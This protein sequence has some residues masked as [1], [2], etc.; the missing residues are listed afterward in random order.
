MIF[1]DLG[2]TLVEIKPKLYADS[3]HKISEASGHNIDAA[4]FQQAIKDEWTHRNGEDIAWVNTE[5]QE[6]HYWQDFYHNVL[7]RLGVASPP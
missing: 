1:F 3:A 7:G 6:Q 2:G 5:E 4:A